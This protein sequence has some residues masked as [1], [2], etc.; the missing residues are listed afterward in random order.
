[1]IR[2]FFYCFV[3]LTVSCASEK[4][5]DRNRQDLRSEGLPVTILSNDSLK[6]D[7][8]KEDIFEDYVVTSDAGFAIQIESSNDA[9]QG[10]DILKSVLDA[11]VT[12]HPYFSKIL[13]Q[14][15][16]GCVYELNVDGT[17]FYQFRKVIV[18]GGKKYIFK[19]FQGKTFSK[20]EI[21]SMFD[22]IQ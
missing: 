16:D 8:R 3:I 17:I 4:S 20:E 9:R 21:E 12:N 5:L 10:K 11:E 18:E 1:M 14:T 6:V 7:Y 13:K 15:E 19:E 2:A 22:A